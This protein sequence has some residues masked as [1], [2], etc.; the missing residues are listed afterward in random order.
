MSL[1]KKIIPFLC[2][3]IAALS[4]ILMMRMPEVPAWQVFVY[5]IV[6][7]IPCVLILLWK[8]FD[9]FFGFA[10]PKVKSE[11][12]WSSVTPYIGW[13]LLVLLILINH[14]ARPPADL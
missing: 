1:I 3:P 14:F 9:Q 2:V 10:P 6:I 12:Q 11:D 5:S 8:P 4:I 13:L 7:V